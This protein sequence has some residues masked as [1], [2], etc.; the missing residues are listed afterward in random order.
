MESF[1]IILLEVL[2]MY[3]LA[4][5]N[6]LRPFLMG[7]FSVMFGLSLS[8]ASFGQTFFEEDFEAGSIN[9][10]PNPVWSWKVAASDSNVV[11][12]M[13]YGSSGQD[14]YSVSDTVSFTGKYS[15]R[16]NFA[17][18]NNWCNQC[19]SV[20]VAVNSGDIAVGCVA[21][22]GGPW[23]NVIF[24]KS[25]G[26]SSWAV[27]RQDSGQVCFNTTTPIGGSTYETSGFAD[28]DLIKVPYQCGVNG[29]VG[30]RINRRSDCNKAINYLDGVLASHLGL[31]ETLARRFYI[32][33]PSGTVL[34]DNT[35]KLGYSHYRKGGRLAASTLKLS[36]SRGLTLSLAAPGGNFVNGYA[37]QKDKWYY[38]EE[39]FTRET[40]TE[41]SDGKYV[42]Y[43]APAGEAV[44][45]P[46][47]IQTEVTIG[48]LKDMSI[49][50]NFQ[51]N[52][53]A[54]GFIYF[55]AI[56]IKDAFI[57]PAGVKIPSSP[58]RFETGS[59]L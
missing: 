25:N 48:E 36:V 40:S 47:L 53:D 10:Q 9:S 54:S 35:L 14:I 56:V 8:A 5:K 50:G 13:M 7:V 58:T 26:F 52:N 43:V 4:N 38:F 19:G 46:Q 33:I 29:I 15:L 6:R 49:N 18:R 30:R 16:L 31:G 3:F 28:G 11:K 34:P 41:G 55:D 32:F 45:A 1:G 17:G 24:N 20:E 51:H 37:I 22:T 44:T 23:N 57:G 21:V 39:I 12:S 59:A 27:T 2:N 42:L